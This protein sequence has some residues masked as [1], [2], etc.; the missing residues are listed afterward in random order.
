M[1][2]NISIEKKHL[3]V[4][5]VVMVFLIGAGYVIA[6]D[7]GDPKVH[8]HTANEIEGGAGSGSIS[9]GDWTDK[10]SLGNTLTGD[11]VYRAECDG[12]ISFYTTSSAGGGNFIYIGET[13]DPTIPVVGSDAINSNEA[14]N[15]P[16]K[17]GEY[18]KIQQQEQLLEDP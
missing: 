5:I 14:G 7:S 8:G 3:Y 17:D 18:V 4:L 1:A 6:W 16:V 15:A 2:I 9:F 13:S 10:D 12:F 11:S